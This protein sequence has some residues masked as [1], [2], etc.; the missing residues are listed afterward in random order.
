MNANYVIWTMGTET[1]ARIVQSNLTK[2]DA[3]RLAKDAAT[4]RAGRT[5]QVEFVGKGSYGVIFYDSLQPT[6]ETSRELFW[7]DEA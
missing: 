2:R 3:E 7:V 1:E 5:G 4:H 6:V